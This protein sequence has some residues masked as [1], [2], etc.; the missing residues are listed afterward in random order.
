ML[1]WLVSVGWSVAKYK[2][3]CVGLTRTI[4]NEEGISCQITA[5]AG[6]VSI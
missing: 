5:V 2:G 1:G 3:V 4:I 6:P